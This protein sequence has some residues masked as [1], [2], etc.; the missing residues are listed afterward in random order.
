MIDAESANHVLKGTEKLMK[1]TGKR[2]TYGLDS[3]RELLEK[4]EW[5]LDG[6]KAVTD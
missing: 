4:L 1:R 3:S 2:A 6:L 5:E